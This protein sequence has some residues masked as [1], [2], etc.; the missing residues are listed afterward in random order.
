MT[1]T[2]IHKTQGMVMAF[3]LLSGDLEGIHGRVVEVEVDL[4]PALSSFVISGLPG[5]GIRE[6][7]ERIRSAIE[8]SGY[9]YPD[10]HR[11]VVNLA[12]AAWEK[13]G[14]VFDL[15]IALS[16]LA[17]S[18]QVDADLFRGWQHS[19]NWPSTA[20]SG[21]CPGAAESAHNCVAPVQMPLLY[22]R[23]TGAWRGRSVA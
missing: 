13:D 22:R 14:S 10:R 6:A 8:N 11:I 19:E 2:S 23:G 18:G 17:A 16:I 15:P 7:R 21:P 3:R 1:L 4:I 9:R 12:P 5:K 20:G